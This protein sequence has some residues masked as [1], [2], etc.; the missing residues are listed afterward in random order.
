DLCA[1][2]RDALER[3][4][5][6][7]LPGLTLP[8]LPE[9]LCNNLCSLRPDVDRLAISCMMRMNG[10]QVMDYEI[11]PSVIHSRARLVYDDVNRMLAGQDNTVPQA[12]HGILKDMAA[13]SQEIRR[14]RTAR[15]SLDF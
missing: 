8:M 3:G 15:G 2:D 7:Y 6:V 1:I 9:A 11:V 12:L 10:S 13:L 14:A 4:T 5:S